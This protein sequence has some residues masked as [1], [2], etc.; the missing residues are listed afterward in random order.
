MASLL[1]TYTASQ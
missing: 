1:T